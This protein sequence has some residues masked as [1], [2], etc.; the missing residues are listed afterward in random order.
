MT[1]HKNFP[2]ATD[3]A[4]DGEWTKSSYSSQ[5]NQNCVETAKRPGLIGVR[6]SKDKAG[7]A[8]AF[9]PAAWTSFIETVN[10][11]EADFGVV[12]S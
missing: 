1:H 3:M 6:D 4:P 2:V 10:S 7:P 12:D 9:T 11:G 5:D 8:L